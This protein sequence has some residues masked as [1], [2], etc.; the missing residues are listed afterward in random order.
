MVLNNRGFSSLEAMVALV[1]AAA[2][3]SILFVVVYL[4]FA[5]IWVRHLSHEAL[6]CAAKGNSSFRCEMKMKKGLELL[7]GFLKP[8]IT[9][10]AD[11]ERFRY[12]LQVQY[13]IH[14][15]NF[16]T[17]HKLNERALWK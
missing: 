1:S 6:L 9:L 5:R 12:Q 3:V 7:G 16:S 13:K 17:V 10:N 2:V 4:C 11:R 14:N 15:W 8:R